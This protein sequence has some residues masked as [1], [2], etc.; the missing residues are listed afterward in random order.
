MMTNHSIESDSLHLSDATG[1]MDRNDL[2]LDLPEP[3]RIAIC[4]RAPPIVL[5]YP[6]ADTLETASWDISPASVLTVGVGIWTAATGGALY[7]ALG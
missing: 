7:F 4:T 1:D 3:P 6:L 5:E 2:E